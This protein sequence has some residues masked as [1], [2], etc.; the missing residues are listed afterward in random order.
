MSLKISLSLVCVPHIVPRTWRWWDLFWQ[1]GNVTCT[2]DFKLGRLSGC[3]YPNHTSPFKA[4]GFLWR[5]V[6][7]EP[8]EAQGPGAL[9][10]LKD[11][12]GHGERSQENFEELRI[13][14]HWLQK[15]RDLS[16]TTMGNWILPT[17]W[18]NLE[19]DFPPDSSDRN[20]VWPTAW[21][22]H[23]ETVG[24]EH[25]HTEVDFKPTELWA[26]KWCSE[27]WNVW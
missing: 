17:T 25:S 3:V 4:E 13:T 11:G 26:N 16:P 18:V 10:Q 19:V 27:S 15:H 12:E 8:E 21:F 22:Q 24:R 1:L 9:C 7:E 6:E 5:V 2:A 23:H 20:T 14:L